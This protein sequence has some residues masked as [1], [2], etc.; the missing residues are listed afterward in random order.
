M[1]RARQPFIFFSLVVLLI[2]ATGFERAADHY[3]NFETPYGAAALQQYPDV[4]EHRFGVN[5]FLDDDVYSWQLQRD[6]EAIKAGGFSWIR[7]EFIWDQI[8]PGFKGNHYDYKNH[9]D[10]WTKWDRIVRFAQEYHI[11]ILARLDFAPAWATKGNPDSG[12]CPTLCPPP[13]NPQDFAD[14]AR[15][16]AER[17]KGKISAFQIWNEPNLQVD[18]AG[19]PISP[20]AY[21]AMLRD[22]YIAIKSVDPG[23]I[24]ITAALAPNRGD[25][26]N[27]MSDLAF[28]RGMYA[29]GAKG[30][31]DVLAAQGYGLNTPAYDRRIGVHSDEFPRILLPHAQP[32][33]LDRPLLLRQIMEANGNGSRPLWITEFGWISLPSHWSGNPSPWSEVSEAQRIRY[34]VQA[35]QR[36]RNE[37]PY[38]GPMFLWYLRTPVKVDPKD[39]TPYFAILGQNWQTGP[40]YKAVQQ[41]ATAPYYA[42]V[43][44]HPVNSP[45]IDYGPYGFAQAWTNR[46]TPATSSA[47]ARAPGANLTFDFQGEEVWLEIVRGPTGG[48]VRVTIDNEPGWAN[49]VPADAQGNHVLNTYAPTQQ[50]PQLI[51]IATGLAFQDHQL[52]LELLPSGRAQTTLTISGFGVANEKPAIWSY[53]KLLL[54]LCASLLVSWPLVAGAR[55]LTHGVERAQRLSGISAVA[56][57]MSQLVHSGMLMGA[58]WICALGLFEATSHQYLVAAGAAA[59][60]ILGLLRPDIGVLFIP[61]SMAFEFLPRQLHHADLS[62]GEVAILA[63]T[64]GWTLRCFWRRRLLL[65]F[66]TAHTLAFALLLV[67]IVSLFA[68]QF[69]R[70]SLR[71][72]R[73]V[74][75]EPVAYL[76]VFTSLLR[77]SQVRRAVLWTIVGGTTVAMLSLIAYIFHRDTVAAEGVVRLAGVYPSP[78]N[79]ALFL[80]R[81]CVMALALSVWSNGKRRIIWLVPSAIMLLVEVLTFTKGAWLA[82]AATLALAG[83][84]VTP[85]LLTVVA[86]GAVVFALAALLTHV[87]RLTTLFQFG[88]QSTAGRRLLLWQAAWHMV[89]GHPLQ[90]IGLD[91]FLYQYRH[92]R[93]PGAGSEPFLSHPHDLFLDFWLSLGLLGLA[94]LIGA[95]VSIG[96]LARWALRRTAASDHGLVWALIGSLVVSFLHGLVDNSFFLPDLAV[97]FWLSV[98]GLQLLGGTVADEQP[99]KAVKES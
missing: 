19:K 32:F 8:E 33:T 68:S 97:L 84:V 65:S 5:T 55:S 46:S 89:E 91:N 64:A 70:F 77:P 82:I 76:F 20:A 58:L 90:G 66:D 79:L 7:Q 87:R 56:R 34:T 37:W 21:T 71:D 10:A 23:A 15:A 86:G 67:S 85:W 28:L 72:F 49:A 43:G 54:A 45:A 35:Y 14:F 57:R 31:F 99:A 18:W 40:V 78:D 50:P 47:I 63:C 17:Y 41:L 42:G 74:I 94:W 38:A 95:V 80:D 53:L 30:Y 3:F 11:H 27:N 24:V 2:I 13:N 52:E 96:R 73:S 62:L 4:P 29:A 22:A 44:L 59:I 6:F 16:V 81:P 48:P 12:K 88:P 98:G 25:S 51:P 26:P 69:V 39:P 1:C 75:V 60:I 83:I 92:Y 9:V 36:A 93:L 61:T